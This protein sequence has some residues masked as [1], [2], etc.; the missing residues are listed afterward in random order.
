MSEFDSDYAEELQKIISDAQLRHNVRLTESE[1]LIE[2]LLDAYP[3]EK[4][5]ERF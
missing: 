4:Y 1:K 3:G 5:G 2:F